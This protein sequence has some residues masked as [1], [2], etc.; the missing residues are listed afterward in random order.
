MTSRWRRLAGRLS[1]SATRLRQLAARSVE[2]FFRDGCPKVAAAISSYALFSVF[3]IAILTVAV[4]G[5]VAADESVSERVVDFLLLPRGERAAGSRGGVRWPRVRSG[6]YDQVEALGA[7]AAAA[8]AGPRPRAAT[9]RTR[10]PAVPRRR[11][12]SVS[13][14]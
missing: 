2:E 12:R 13:R 9:V 5:L 6:H 14:A 7:G 10:A 11:W 1:V 3:P 8:R 4:F